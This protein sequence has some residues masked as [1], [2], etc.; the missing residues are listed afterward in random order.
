MGPGLTGARHVFASL[1]LITIAVTGSTQIFRSKSVP[2]NG[3]G[4]YRN[5]ILYAPGL[6]ILHSKDLPYLISAFA[7]SRAGINSILTIK[8]LVVLVFPS[9]EKLSSEQ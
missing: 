7:K 2:D 9:S 5:P 4:T 8:F 3:D 1:V 6:P